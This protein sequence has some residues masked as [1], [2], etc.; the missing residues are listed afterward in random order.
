MLEIFWRQDNS[1]AFSVFFLSFLFS[2]LSVDISD[3]WEAENV[4]E[5]VDVCFTEAEF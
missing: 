1:L 5:H 2:S 4:D 3:K